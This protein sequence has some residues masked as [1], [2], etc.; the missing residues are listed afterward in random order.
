[1][2]R[3][4]TA[5][6]QEEINHAWQWIATNLPASVPIYTVVRHRTDTTSWITLLGVVN[7]EIVDI[8][9]HVVRV[10]GGMISPKYGGAMWGGTG[11]NREFDIVHALS[12]KMFGL[13]R[14]KHYAQ[15]KI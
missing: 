4:P 14:R 8:T 1:M 3:K 9:Y 15:R 13:D 10:L 2:A 12:L 11:L 5:E 6:Q 7:G